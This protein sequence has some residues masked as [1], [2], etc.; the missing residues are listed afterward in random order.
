MDAF[1]SSCGRIFGPFW[2]HVELTNRLG[3]SL[4]GLLSQEVGFLGSTPPILEGFG[5]VLGIILEIFWYL[6][7]I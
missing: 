6:L 7:S 2:V 3:L 4:R 5:Q 1:W